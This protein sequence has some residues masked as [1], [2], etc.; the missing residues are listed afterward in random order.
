MSGIQIN[1]QTRIE[2][3]SSSGAGRIMYAQCQTW[4]SQC[5]N[6][7]KP[8]ARRPVVVSL[9]KLA[10]ERASLASNTAAP[11]F[12]GYSNSEMSFPNATAMLLL[13]VAICSLQV[14]QSYPAAA[15]QMAYYHQQPL[16]RA[17]QPHQRV[18][19]RHQQPAYINKYALRRSSAD[20][21]A[22]PAN[23]E[24]PVLLQGELEILSTLLNR[25][26]HFQL[27]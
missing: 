3:L 19:Y 9:W 23:D 10:F 27:K 2:A 15:G 13:V 25:M 20:E 5:H 24:I 16:Y 21:V 18:Y 11:I 7:I 6:T 12:Q 8:I 1:N 26:T 17:Y 4:W 14:A 22:P